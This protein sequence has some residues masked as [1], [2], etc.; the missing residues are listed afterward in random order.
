MRVPTCKVSTSDLLYFL[1]YGL[2]KKSV[3]YNHPPNQ[4][5]RRPAPT[6]YPIKSVWQPRTS[7]ASRK[8]CIKTDRLFNNA[9]LLAFTKPENNTRTYSPNA[10]R[11]TTSLDRDIRNT[12]RW[13]DKWSDEV[14]RRTNDSFSASLCVKF[15]FVNESWY[16]LKRYWLSCPYAIQILVL[17]LCNMCNPTTTYML[18]ICVSALTTP[19]SARSINWTE[20]LLKNNVYT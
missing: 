20:P 16:W 9:L 12:I 5:P 11:W 6:H 19:V 17:V 14:K 8:R 7:A 15:C 18:T 3:T 2:T 13:L 1:R 4:P 10:N